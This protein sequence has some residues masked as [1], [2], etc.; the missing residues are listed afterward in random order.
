MHSLFSHAYG[1]GADHY[2]DAEFV[3]GEGEVFTLNDK[4]V[5]NPFRFDPNGVSSPGICTQM[6][7]RLYPTTGDETGTLVP[8]SDLGEAVAMAREVGRRRI[9]FAAAVLGAE[10][11][12]AFIAP[13]HRT[14]ERLKGLFRE[15]MGFGFGLIVLGTPHDMAAVK[16]LAPV[17]IDPTMARTL[18]L[19][20]SR[21]LKKDGWALLSGLAVGRKPVE[22]LLDP[23][24]APLIE[25]ALSPSPEG[26]A[27]E[28][29]EDMRPFYRQLYA[30]PEMT[31]LVWLNMFR[32]LAARM[33][34]SRSVQG[35]VM[36]VPLDDPGAIAGLCG[37]LKSVGERHGLPNDFAYLI[38]LDFGKRAVM[39]YDFYHDHTDPEERMRAVAAI[40]EASSV[41]DRILR[42][43]RGRSSKAVAHQGHCRKESLLYTE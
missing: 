2:T 32:I 43:M 22:V 41:A 6:T 16:T 39:K 4:D 30:R 18:M 34:R 35:M 31:D 40:Q 15:K 26:V 10:Y 7:V 17:T 42:P 3:G 36:Y 23:A 37:D 28:V 9:G 11:T 20:V 29:D 25:A 14:A 33:G 19:S 5:P 13:T 12:S 8:F 27:S 24:L 1:M 38:P 21:L